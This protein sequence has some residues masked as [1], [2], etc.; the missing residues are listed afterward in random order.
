MGMGHH[1]LFLWQ[2]HPSVW[3]G[4]YPGLSEEDFPFFMAMAPWHNPRPRSFP[5]SWNPQSPQAEEEQ[6]RESSW[7]PVEVGS[8]SGRSL[9]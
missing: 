2:E 9:S 4:H 8:P 1:C 3:P 7:G 6:E 5:R